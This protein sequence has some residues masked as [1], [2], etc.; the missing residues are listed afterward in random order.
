MLYSLLCRVRVRSFINTHSASSSSS[1]SVT[2]PPLWQPSHW[3]NPQAFQITPVGV[4]FYTNHPRAGQ[5]CYQ[6]CM[7]PGVCN[8]GAEGQ[9][10]WAFSWW[11]TVSFTPQMNSLSA[12][13]PGNSKHTE[14]W[15]CIWD[16]SLVSRYFAVFVRIS[17]PR[18]HTC[19]LLRLCSC[20]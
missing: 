15:F 19:R 17:G 1:S 6:L 14:G 18:L 20:V 11:T 10:I 16:P 12:S 3:C 5:A 8:Q 2:L 9:Q 13:E 7:Q 4:T